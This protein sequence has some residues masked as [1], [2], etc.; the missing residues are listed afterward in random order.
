MLYEDG[1]CH[2]YGNNNY[3]I[4]CINLC[5]ILKPL[6]LEKNYNSLGE[7]KILSCNINRAV[8]K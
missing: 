8:S 6:N 2:L 4:D 7:E 1:I 5:I 3:L